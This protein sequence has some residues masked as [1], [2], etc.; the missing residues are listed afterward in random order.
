MPID[1]LIF[2]IIAA[3]LAFRLKSLLGTRNGDERQRP[4]P[5]AQN[6][7]LDDKRPA[8]PMQDGVIIDHDPDALKNHVPVDLSGMIDDAANIDGRIEQGLED[9]ARAD[10]H[11][12]VPKFVQGARTAFEW[13]ILAY[14]KGDLETLKPLVSP[15]LY[16]DFAAGVADRKAKGHVNDLT[17]HRIKKSH[18]I[19]AHLGGTMAYVTIDF[20]VEETLVTKDANGAIIDGDPDRIMTVAD[21]WT[22]TRDTRS[23]DP[24]WV[25]IETRT[26]DR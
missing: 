25:L 8:T 26:A 21:V 22:F 15:K 18:I 23:D 16:A 19:E 6:E 24:T 9:I 14:A 7:N 4:N 17:L 20:D 10:R 1:I 3:F 13:I 12:D 5:F 2:A 11:F